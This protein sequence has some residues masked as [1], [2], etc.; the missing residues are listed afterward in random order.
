MKKFFVLAICLMAFLLEGCNPNASFKAKPFS[1]SPSKQVYFSSGNLQYHPVNNEW[2][3]AETQFDYIGDANVNCSST[4]NGWLDLFGS[5]TSVN[6]GVSTSTNYRE[7]RGI[8]ID[9]GTN[10]IGSDAPNT[11]RTMARSE[12]KYVVFDRPNARSLRGVA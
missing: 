2:R 4:Y 6:F 9:W 8:F 3:F 10:Q 12:W 11:W 7:A 5:T 1:V